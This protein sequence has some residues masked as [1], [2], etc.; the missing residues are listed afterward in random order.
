MSHP[1]YQSLIPR[2]NEIQTEEN[3]KQDGEYLV[4]L[5][6]AVEDSSKKYPGEMRIRIQFRVASGPEGKYSNSVISKFYE[7]GDDYGLGDFKRDLKKIGFDGD[8]TEAVD[9]LEADGKIR[10][11]KIELMTNKKGYQNVFVNLDSTPF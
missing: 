6:K 11:Y 5:E 1:Y 4:C 10:D 9:W 7:L 3:K 2:W 8:I